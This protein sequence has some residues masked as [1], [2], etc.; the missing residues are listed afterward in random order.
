MKPVRRKTATRSTGGALEG[1]RVSSFSAFAS[2]PGGV[3]RPAPNADAGVS[4][5][6]R[7][8]AEFDRLAA[9]RRGRE[10]RAGWRRGRK[11]VAER[12]RRAGFRIATP[13]LPLPALLLQRQALRLKIDCARHPGPLAR[14][15][16]A[17]RALVRSN[18]HWAWSFSNARRRASISTN[19]W[20]TVRCCWHGCSLSSPGCEVSTTSR[21]MGPMLS[22][23]PA[24]SSDSSKSRPL[25]RV[26]GDQRRTTVRCGPRKIRQCTAATLSAR[27]RRVQLAPDPTE[28]FDD[29]RRTSWPSRPD[30]HTRSTRKP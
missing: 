21:S 11:T 26:S 22:Q 3:G 13:R 19:C 29:C 27:N 8:G 1:S 16:S 12:R 23:L 25:S 5:A 15:S 10:T 6:G 14:S 4:A 28:H 2:Q 7:P 24:R 20:S 17:C 30:P 18:S 9:A